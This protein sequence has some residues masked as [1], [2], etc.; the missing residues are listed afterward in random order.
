[1]GGRTRLTRRSGQMHTITITIMEEHSCFFFCI[2]NKNL[3]KSAKYRFFFIK[4]DKK[5]N[6]FLSFY[7]QSY[8]RDMFYGVFYAL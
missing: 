4:Y 1:M 2:Q 7:P 3:C 8:V 5:T 6:F